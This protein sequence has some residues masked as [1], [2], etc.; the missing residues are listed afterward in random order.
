M[1]KMD[2]WSFDGSDFVETLDGIGA[3]DERTLV[4]PSLGEPQ[5][6]AGD[7]IIMYELGVIKTGPH[8]Y[9]ATF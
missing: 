5:A 7:E 3:Q 1:E 2:Q 4:R 6:P 8:S 9:E